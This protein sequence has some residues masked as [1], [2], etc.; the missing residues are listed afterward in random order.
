MLLGEAEI[1]FADDPAQNAMQSEP[2]A[3]I[4]KLLFTDEAWAE[5]ETIAEDGWLS[6][7]ELESM[8]V[9]ARFLES[10]LEIE[11]T[12]PMALRRPIPLGAGWR[13][14]GLE[15]AVRVEPAQWS[16]VLNLS[17]GA[18]W[19][20]QLESGLAA[21]G[22]LS[23]HG[24]TLE[25]SGYVGMGEE[26]I[27]GFDSWRVVKP[28]AGGRRIMQVGELRFP[29]G[30]EQRIRPIL[31]AGLGN[32]LQVGRGGATMVGEREFAL[33]RPATAELYVNGVRRGEFRL[34]PNTYSVGD[35][36]MGEGAND[37]RIVL[38]DDTGR[39]EV[40]AFDVFHDR[41]LLPVGET[42][43]S[44]QAGRID[45][46]GAD[47]GGSAVSVWAAR[48]VGETLTVESG[49]QMGGG[50]W[51][52]QLSG[53]KASAWGQWSALVAA[54][55]EGWASE[56]SWRDGG[57]AG[58]WSA[59]ATA[60]MESVGYALW[61]GQ[62]R[63]SAAKSVSVQAQRPLGASYISLGL[64]SR[65]DGEGWRQ[66]VSASWSRPVGDAKINLSGGWSEAR[67][68]ADLRVGLSM[69]LG[70]GDVRAQLDARAS[71]AQLNYSRWSE[72][73]SARYDASIN[74]DP[75]AQA[76]LFETRRAGERY[77]GRAAAGW[78]S[79]G[80]GPAGMDA[81]VSFSSAVVMAGGVWGVSRPV[82]ESFAL[83]TTNPEIGKTFLGVNRD[84]PS[85]RATNEFGPAVL[86]N[87]GNFGALKIAVDAPELDMAYSLGAAESPL[88]A[89]AGYRTGT[90][91]RVGEAAGS[92]V[93]GVLVNE[94]GEPLAM[95][96]IFDEEGQ[97]AAFTGA[98]GRF[99]LDG[100]KPGVLTFKAGGQIYRLAIEEGAASM[101]DAG[102]LSPA[103]APF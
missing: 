74:A 78:R 68:G 1:R 9:E 6:F 51:N 36:A 18:R 38:R 85:W 75:E 39:E 69:P 84:G 47:A 103:A 61:G 83:V 102:V 27:A 100:A 72:D 23:A 64:D 80:E 54:S 63:D 30:R 15:N 86:P 41:G 46:T 8:E 37:V 94:A 58:E 88:A 10:V 99:F 73:G 31:G 76:A 65:D 62:P 82:G 97:A 95:A 26:T 35:L 16:G 81:A 98:D 13:D 93:Q 19:S 42:L 90:L 33:D 92:M 50:A 5:F 25:G 52:A 57:L 60:R 28:F 7:S 53:V 29:A 17:G 101:I 59:A 77:F 45:E 55:D 2:V 66:A 20:D 12:V 67:G 11:W 96:A 49:L 22:A 32:T 48:G 44:V 14:P 21:E 89:W 87:L 56:A 24:W 79:E 43:W 3:R 4:A 91:I 71:S 40:L 34:A 70:G